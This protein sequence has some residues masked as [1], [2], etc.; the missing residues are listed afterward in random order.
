MEYITQFLI[1]ADALPAW[2][3]AIT[4]VVTAA[5]AITIL[6][7]TKTDDKIISTILK[8]LNVIAG[9]VGKN[10]NADAE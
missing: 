1:W 8:V 7:P 9:N 2:V 4:T 5:T 3:A 10:K 6:T